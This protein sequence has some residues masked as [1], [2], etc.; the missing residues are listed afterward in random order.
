M[1]AACYVVFVLILVQ[2][3]SN[4]SSCKFFMLNEDFMILNKEKKSKKS[5]SDFHFT[6]VKL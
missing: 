1:G 2:Y 4:H 6:L 5:L 3:G